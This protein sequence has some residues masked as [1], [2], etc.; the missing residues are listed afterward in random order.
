LFLVECRN[1][2]LDSRLDISK[3]LP[4]VGKKVVEVAHVSGRET[5]EHILEI[6]ESIYVQSLASLY[7]A[8][9]DCGGVSTFDRAREQP[10]VASEND[11]FDRAFAGVVG[12]IDEAGIGVDTKSLPTIE[13]VRDS[14]VELALGWFFVNVFVEP[15]FEEFEFRFGESLAHIL[16]LFLRKIFCSSFNIEEAFDHTH[17]KFGRDIIKEPGIFEGAMNV[18]PAGCGNGAGGNYAVELIGAVGQE[19]TFEAFEDFLWV[20]GVLGFGE[21]VNGVRARIISKHGP[22]DALVHFAQTSFYHRHFGGVSHDDSTL[23][24]EHLHSFDDWFN[25]FGTTAH[26]AAHGG[27]IDWKTE[28]LEHLFLAVERQVKEEFVGIDFGQKS[29][30]RLTFIN[31]LERFVGGKDVL[32]TFLAAVLVD[33]VFDFFEDWFDEISLRGDL[34]AEDSSFVAAAWASEMCCIGDAVRFVAM[35]YARGWGRG[36]AAAV[37]FS[38][39]D[40]E[41]TF[42]VFQFCGCLSMDSF[43]RAGEEG[44][45]DFGGFSTE[46]GAITSAQLFLKVGD[47]CEELANEVVAIGEIIRHVSGF[48]RIGFRRV[49]GHVFALAVLITILYRST[50]CGINE[51]GEIRGCGVI[52]FA[53]SG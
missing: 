47:S 36:A 28:S 38:L 22:D 45:I 39:N 49:F 46:G 2:L 40:V 30:S 8:H 44:R 10:V 21:I 42:L 18:S 43:A 53:L 24:D 11:G 4:S 29:R 35:L 27:A 52:R 6:F 19:N 13:S 50:A 17:R 12:D 1:Y 20:D 14:V 41:R 48:G 9:E 15:T 33:D 25:E 31:S 51:K 7:K 5:S 37:I 32:P 34:E 23:Q 16:A 26:P 3:S